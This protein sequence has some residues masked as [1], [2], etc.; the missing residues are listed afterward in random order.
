LKG[1]HSRWSPFKLYEKC[2]QVRKV[3][4]EVAVCGVG[5]RIEVGCCLSDEMTSMI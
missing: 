1:D 2:P 5:L 4:A 3:S